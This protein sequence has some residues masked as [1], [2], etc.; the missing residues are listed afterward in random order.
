MN[1]LSNAFK[2]TAPGGN[3]NCIV[4]IRT[5]TGTDIPDNLTI[6]VEDSGDC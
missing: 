5:G 1:L 6:R 4:N 2:F 3:V